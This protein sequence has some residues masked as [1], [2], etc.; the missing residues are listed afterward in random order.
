MFRASPTTTG[1]FLTHGQQCVRQLH[2]VMQH[3]KEVRDQALMKAV[4]RLK[5]AC[6]TFV[7]GIR[8][9]LE[10]AGALRGYSIANLKH[11]TVEGVEVGSQIVE[12]DDD[13]ADGDSDLDD[14][15]GALAAVDDGATD[16]MTEAPSEAG[17]DLAGEVQGLLDDLAGGGDEDDEVG[18]HGEGAGDDNQMDGDDA[19]DMGG[20]ADTDG[21]GPFDDED[22]VDDD[23]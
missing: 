21:H 2:T 23:E 17:I 6:E 15:H 22:D 8:S 19:D 9:E 1:R 14:V 5:Q 12:P 20:E 16:G 4:P 11:R 10:R 13:E 7:L 3:G 18:E